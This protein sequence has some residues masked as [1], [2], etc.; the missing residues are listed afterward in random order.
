M[1]QNK[2][3]P[4]TDEENIRNLGGASGGALFGASASGIPGAIVGAVIG[5]WASNE[6]NKNSRK[7][8]SSQKNERKN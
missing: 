5:L 3:K 6:V 8:L 4:N 1:I 7:K 2:N